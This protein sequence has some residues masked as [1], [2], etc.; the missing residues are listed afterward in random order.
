MRDRRIA[1]VHKGVK[2]NHPMGDTRVAAPNQN[3]VGIIQPIIKPLLLAC[4][5]ALITG[6][7]WDDHPCAIAIDKHY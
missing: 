5:T 7:T 2:K 3:E 4:K 1:D 6:N